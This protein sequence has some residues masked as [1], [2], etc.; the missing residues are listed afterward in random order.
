MAVQRLGEAH[1]LESFLLH[2]D[3]G[4]ADDDDDYHLAE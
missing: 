3:D 1:S 4:A 2:S